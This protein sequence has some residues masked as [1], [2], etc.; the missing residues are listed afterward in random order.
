MKTHEVRNC[1]KIYELVQ[2][3]KHMRVLTIPSVSAIT[4]TATVKGSKRRYLRY[5]LRLKK[6]RINKHPYNHYSIQ[7]CPCG[8]IRQFLDKMNSHDDPFWTILKEHKK[9]LSIIY[10]IN[11]IVIIVP[12]LGLAWL[13]WLVFL[14]RLLFFYALLPDLKT[15]TILGTILLDTAVCRVSQ[16]SWIESK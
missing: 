15:H 7:V 3:W 10:F 8:L 9:W 2:T 11:L 1:A 5:T 14:T 6:G 13:A 4:W 16:F 12:T